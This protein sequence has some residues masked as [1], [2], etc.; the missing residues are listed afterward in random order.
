MMELFVSAIFLARAMS[1]STFILPSP[2]N[3]DFNS[4]ERV[5]LNR[6]FAELKQSAHDSQLASR[7]DRVIRQK[8]IR[9]SKKI[10][11]NA[12][13]VSMTALSWASG[14]DDEAWALWRKIRGPL[15]EGEVEVRPLCLR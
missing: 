1:L 9:R 14:C 5:A 3:V 2:P 7:I 10:L 6:A 8:S 12:I 15:A 13:P 4:A 11:P